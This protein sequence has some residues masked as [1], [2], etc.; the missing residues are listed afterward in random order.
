MKELLLTFVLAG[1]VSTL[2]A[3]TPQEKY[4]PLGRLIMVKLESAPF[5]HPTRA[6]GHKYGN[7]EYDAATH[8]SDNTVG[9]FVPKGFR[10]TDKVDFVVHFHG[11]RN[12]VENVLGHYELPQQFA[13]SGRNAILVV[14]QGPY[15]A[16]DSSGGKLEDE[17]GFKRFMA[18]V[19]ETLRKEGVI[20]KEPMGDVILCGHSGGYKVISAIVTRGGLEEKVKEVWLFDALYANA[21]QFMGWFKRFPDRRMIMI[22]TLHG[23]TKEETEKLM[24]S[25]KAA[26]PE[27]PFLAKKE[28]QMTESDLKDNKLIFIYTDLEHDLV[29]YAHHAFREYLKTSGLKP[30]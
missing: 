8:Y 11:W 18:D 21:D 3:E 24:A 19:M 5:P 10:R 28:A 15:D 6:K 2:R 30:I 22:Y 16:P 1:V 12:H 13:E 20:E 7:Q 14:P 9:I 27:T 29:P 4:A 17:N 26:K 25:L 23:G